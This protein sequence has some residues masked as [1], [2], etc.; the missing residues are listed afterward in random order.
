M[1]NTFLALLRKL[2]EEAGEPFHPVSYTHLDVYKRQI[3]AFREKMDGLEDNI[4]ST[5]GNKVVAGVPMRVYLNGACLTQ[6]P[7]ID[8]YLEMAA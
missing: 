1:E 7:M 3:Q 5:E 2:R 8:V 4:H 6:I